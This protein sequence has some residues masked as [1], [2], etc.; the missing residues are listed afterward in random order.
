MDSIGKTIEIMTKS[1]TILTQTKSRCSQNPLS[2]RCLDSE[3]HLKGKCNIFRLTIPEILEI[4]RKIQSGEN[5]SE[6]AKQYPISRTSL[7]ET[8]KKYYAGL[9]EPAIEQYYRQIK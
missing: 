1:N 4:N 2:Y 5:I 3:G 7:V 8:M 6:I 9:F